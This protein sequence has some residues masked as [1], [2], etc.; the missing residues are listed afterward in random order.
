MQLPGAHVHASAGAAKHGGRL[1][2]PARYRHLGDV[3]RLIIAGLLLAG[4]L[5]VTVA[6]HD[7]YASAGVAAVTAVVHPA[8]A[9][10]V[11]AG[12]VQ[13][14]FIL[15]AV[16]VLAVTLHSRRFGLL[17]SLAGGAVVASAVL[18]GTVML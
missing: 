6:T 10:E 4:A 7:T 3:I 16:A 13:A 14:V 2:R 15:G 18:A 11:L 17:V 5:V 9:G 1:L 12:L 8:L